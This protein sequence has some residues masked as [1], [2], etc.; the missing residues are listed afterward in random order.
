[1]TLQ[2]CYSHNTKLQFAFEWSNDMARTLYRFHS[3]NKTN[4][5]IRT[6]FHWFCYKTIH[7]TFGRLIQHIIIIILEKNGYR[8]RDR[9]SE[10]KKKTHTLMKKTLEQKKF[11]S[12][13]H[14]SLSLVYAYSLKSTIK[15]CW[16]ISD[17]L[18][19]CL[20]AIGK[21]CAEYGSDPIIENRRIEQQT[22]HIRLTL[23]LLLMSQQKRKPTHTHKK[24]TFLSI[25]SM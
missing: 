16:D 25:I 6:M 4:R 3:N 14:Y 18:F 2:L 5:P 7:D 1:M 9:V 8:D 20:K 19:V 12:S 10:S 24:K 21:M 15:T 22:I 23:C 17:H 13:V 11:E